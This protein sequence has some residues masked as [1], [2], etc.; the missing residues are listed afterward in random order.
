MS[1]TKRELLKAID[2]GLSENICTNDMKE[3]YVLKLLQYNVNQIALY[4][5]DIVNQCYLVPQCSLVNNTHSKASRA[6][7]QNTAVSFSISLH[8]DANHSSTSASNETQGYA[9][10]IIARREP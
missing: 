6:Y 5:K 7:N 4:Y 8:E 9:Q 2:N 10:G 1:Q 3:H